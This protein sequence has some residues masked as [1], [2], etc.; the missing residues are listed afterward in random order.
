MG[1]VSLFHPEV[2]P[3]RVGASATGQTEQVRLT[4]LSLTPFVVA[5]LVLTGCS[6]GSPAASLDVKASASGAPT[7]SAT[8]PASAA[9]VV[10]ASGG[11]SGATSAGSV[12]GASG[13]SASSP[14]PATSAPPA[15]RPAV[16]TA[17]GAVAPSKATRAGTY[18]YDTSGKVTLGDPGTPQDVSGS[19]TLTVTPVRAGGQRFTLHSE[20]TGDTI[21]DVLVRDSGTYLSVLRLNT[22][23]FTK[24]F[25]ANPAALLVPDPAT[26]GRTY[27]T[28]GTSTD[29]KTQI[30]SRSKVART[31][32]LTIGGR[33]VPC[34]VVTNHLELTG[35]VTYTADMTTWWSPAHRLSVKDHTVGKGSY[36]GFPFSTDITSVLRSVEAS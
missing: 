32:T 21:E 34:V 15:A 14:T 8:S 1:S 4:R 28:S 31:E 30:A 22:P 25:R 7:A 23:A 11:T 13:T 9:P 3:G 16:T 33:R 12:A 27:S 24:E 18:T 19:P 10:T 6:G 35:D 17:P 29:G 2:L 5:G 36:N 20:N 26:L